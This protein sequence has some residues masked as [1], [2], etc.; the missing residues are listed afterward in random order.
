[1]INGSNKLI[2]LQRTDTSDTGWKQDEVAGLPGTFAEVVIA[3]HPNGDVWA[4]CLLQQAPTDNAPVV[5]ALKL[6][7]KSPRPDGTVEC[8]WKPQADA[9][10]GGWA[11][12]SLCVS[13]SP[14]AGPLIMSWADQDWHCYLTTVY[15]QFPDSG[16]ATELK[17]RVQGPYASIGNP[18]SARRVVG[19][20][21]L[22]YSSVFRKGKVYVFYLLD[23]ATLARYILTP[24]QQL[25][26]AVCSST[27]EQFC[28]TWNVPNL[29]QS[30][31]RGDIGSISLNSTNGDLGPAI[32]PPPVPRTCRRGRPHWDSSRPRAGRT[33]TGRSTSSARCPF[34]P[35]DP[36]TRVCAARPR[37][38]GCVGETGCWRAIPQ[39][40]AT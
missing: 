3:V 25:T 29:P 31:P 30:F 13:Y 5:Q 39:P 20:G 37:G 38:G 22:P 10:Q 7:S 23:G 21:F 2:Y 19:G 11:A 26:S 12:R 4:F 27:V 36:S 34:R 35:D 15:A 8:E 17:P 40:D 32:A 28:R 9:I 24:D 6:I 14:D 1:V 16:T 33:Q 18:N